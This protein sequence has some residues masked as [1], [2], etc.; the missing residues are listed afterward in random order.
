[1]WDESKPY[2]NTMLA[3]EKDHR[4]QMTGNDLLMD[5]IINLIA[6][7]VWRDLCEAAFDFAMQK[8]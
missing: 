7:G 6:G 5:P 4:A 8:S 1:M 3:V 2:Q